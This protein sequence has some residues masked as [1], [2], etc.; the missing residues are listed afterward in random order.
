MSIT[1]IVKVLPGLLVCM[2]LAGS[3]QSQMTPKNILDRS[4]KAHGGD[5]LTNWDTMTIKGTIDMVDGITFRA[6]YRLF[7]K[8]PGKL[9]VERDMTVVQG[10]RIFYDYFLNSGIAWS[11]RNLVPSSGNLDEMNRWLNQCYGI[12]YYAN[13]AESLALKEDA[14]V[15]WR[16][17]ADLQSNDYKVVATRPAYVIAAVI[18]K[19]TV[20]LFID[21][22]NFYFLQETTGRSKRVFWDFKKFGEVTLPAKILEIVAASQGE[23]ITPYTY[24]S[25]TYNVPIEDWLFT[26]DMPQKKLDRE[27]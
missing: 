17:K 3:A 13:K 25:V 16:E 11:R 19:E 1:T 14:V 12:A 27:P 24:E 15:E 26:E 7:A 8:V 9:R 6:A 18:G 20:S 2:V 21:K 23:R 5:R 22:E 4:V 10:G